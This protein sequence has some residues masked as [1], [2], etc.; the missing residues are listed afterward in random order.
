[1]SNGTDLVRKLIADIV[2]AQKTYTSLAFDEEEAGK[3]RPASTPDKIAGLERKFG[4][5]LPSSVKMFLSVY[6]GVEAFHVD[7]VLLGTEDHGMPWVAKRIADFNRN[8]QDVEPNPFDNHALPLMMGPDIQ[9]FVII[10]YDRMNQDGEPL[11][12]E[13]DQSAEVRTFPDI[14][15]FLEAELATLQGMIDRQRHGDIV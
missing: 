6:N 1:M 7:G 10:A 14:Q 2:D 15:T 12:V 5:A 13:Y 8:W 9:H 4:H 3:P 11:L